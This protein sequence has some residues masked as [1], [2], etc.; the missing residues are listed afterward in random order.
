L[1]TSERT[2]ACTRRRP[3]RLLRKLERFCPISE[4]EQRTLMSAISAERVFAPGEDLIHEHRQTEGVFVIVDGFACRYKLLPNGRRQIVGFL[5]PGDM[6]D[7][8]VFLLRRMDHSIAALGPV[9]ALQIPP[10]AALGLLESSTR[11][12]RAL[13]WSTVVEDSITREWIVNVGYRSAFERVAH[14]F[15][16]IFWRLESVGLARDNQCH[17]PLTQIELGDTLA[18]SS[19]HINR[20]LMGMRRANLVNLHRGHL[21]LLNRPALELAAG[22]DPTYLHLEGGN[23]LVSRGRDKG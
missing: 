17:L 5:L 15:C 16:E 7:L 2:E 23:P 21:E 12:T 9:S 18:L 14:L 4:E 13:W 22:F 20:T 11:L 8:R 10:D 3:E 1:N 6:C 19:V